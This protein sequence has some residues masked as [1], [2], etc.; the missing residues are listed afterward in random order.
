MKLL[1]TVVKK[2]RP[3]LP[4]RYRT[5]LDTW[6]ILNEKYAHLKTVKLGAC[7]DKKKRPLP[8]Y[9]YPAIEFIQ[10]LDWKE[11]AIFEFGCGN[12]TLFWAGLAK[13]VTA[14]ESDPVWHEKI[15]SKMPAHV[16]LVL[17]PDLKAYVAA[18]EKFETPFDVI[19]V[20]GM[21]RLA[22]AQCAR[23]LLKEGGVMILDNSDWYPKTSA[24]LRDS[25]LLEV[26]MSGFGPIN[27]YTWTTSFYF[28]RQFRNLPAQEQEPMGG[29]GS[30]KQFGDE[31]E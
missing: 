11:K 26:D 17:E 16:Q 5:S 18:I 23:P 10:Q 2:V 1:Q 19:I 7:V 24:F 13:S 21:K 25:N 3:F 9:T 15:S 27:P 28:H 4:V 22:A 6:K 20:D 12:S 30:I 8:W 14:I 31:S 29:I